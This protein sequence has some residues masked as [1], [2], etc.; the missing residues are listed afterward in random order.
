MERRYRQ[1]LSEMRLRALVRWIMPRGSDCCLAGCRPLTR[2]EP[3]PAAA[4]Y[5]D[6][7][8]QS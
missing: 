6:H 3:M 1:F 7:R 2:L 4:A 5:P 8:A